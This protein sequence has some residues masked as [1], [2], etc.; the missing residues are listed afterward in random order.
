VYEYVPNGGR[1]IDGPT[2]EG[3][4]T[5]IKRNKPGMAYTMLLVILM[6]K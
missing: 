1:N 4:P 2:K 5:A 6:V 3:G